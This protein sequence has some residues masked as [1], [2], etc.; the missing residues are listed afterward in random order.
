MAVDA[1]VDIV[2]MAESPLYDLIPYHDLMAKQG[3]FWRGVWFLGRCSHRIAPNYR[4]F[5]KYIS[6]FV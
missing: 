1:L 6:R 5:F 4:K 3:S 2:D